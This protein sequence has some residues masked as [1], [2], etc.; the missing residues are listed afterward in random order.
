MTAMGLNKNELEH[1]RPGISH[2]QPWPDAK[3]PA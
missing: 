1:Q 2:S 3:N